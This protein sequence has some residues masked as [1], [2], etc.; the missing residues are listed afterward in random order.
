MTEKAA[1]VTLWGEVEEPF[2]KA[3]ERYGTWP[4]TVWDCDMSDP[5]TK[6]LK[7]LVGDAGQA[8]PDVFTKATQDK[9][10]YRGKVTTTIFNPA[11]ASWLLNLYAPPTPATVFDPFAGGGT[12]AIIAG[13][14]GLDYIGCELRAEEVASSMALVAAAGV[15]GSVAIEEADAA[16]PPFPDASADLLLTCPPYWNLEQYDGGPRD[17]SMAATYD[18]FLDMLYPVVLASR[19]VLKLGARS[20]WVVGL[21]RDK[22]GTL[23]PMHHDLATLH[24]RAGFRFKEEIILAQRN[25]GAIQRV[26]NFERGDRRLVRTHEYALVFER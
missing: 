14:K 17:L 4:V 5:H 19:R 9:S 16:A 2:E 24:R 11:V 23:L 21:H 6:R 25:N 3:V 10:L 20:L 7:A 26:G 15:A 18:E 22:A 12:R 8:R 1:A 13:A